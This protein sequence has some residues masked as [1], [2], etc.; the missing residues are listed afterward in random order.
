M[1]YSLIVTTLSLAALCGCD[2][3]QGPNQADNGGTVMMDGPPPSTVDVHAHP[4]EGPHHGVLVEL[5]KE[6]FH[7]EVVHTK[8]AVTVYILDSAAEKPV[9]V[10][11]TEI[12]INVL[13]DGKPEQFKLAAAPD[14]GDS[15]G[16]CSRFTLADTDLVSHIDDAASQPKLSLTVSGKSY[17]GEIKHDHAGHDHAGHDHAH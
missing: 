10:D 7:A 16:K 2:S 13:H 5:G 8:D 17:R 4:T 14:A 15:D 3:G 6:D 9:P 12:L 11:A 1:R